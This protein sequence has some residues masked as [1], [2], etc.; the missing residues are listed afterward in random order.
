MK[1]EYLVKMLEETDVGLSLTLCVDGSIISGQMI[2]S[3]R[4]F[5]EMSTYFNQNSSTADDPSLIEKGLGSGK[6]VWVWWHHKKPESELLERD[7]PKPEFSNL[8][9]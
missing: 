5:E 3:K 2:S 4:Y 8:G 9:Q 6:G 1:L 7:M